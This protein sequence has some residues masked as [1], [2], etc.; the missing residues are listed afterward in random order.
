MCSRPQECVQQSSC[1]AALV[2][3][4]ISLLPCC[5]SVVQQLK[6]RAHPTLCFAQAWAI[7]DHLRQRSYDGCQNAAAVGWK[8]LE[9]GGC[10]LDAAEA[11]VRVLEDDDAFD[12]S[13]AGR[14]ASPCTT[15][16][17]VRLRKQCCNVCL[18][19][20]HSDVGGNR[21]CAEC[22]WR[23]GDGCNDD[24]RQQFRVRSLPVR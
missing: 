24:G 10:A 21:I 17:C 19:C 13:A 1:M 7:P 6:T 12:V 5:Y 9:A 8:V 11:A 16:M 23:G 2:L 22:C 3:V 14:L 18:H 15:C 20:L 4:Y